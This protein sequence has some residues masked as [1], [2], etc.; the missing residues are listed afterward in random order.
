MYRKV[1]LLNFATDPPFINWASHVTNKHNVNK[2]I[3]MLP[4]VF[5]GDFCLDAITVERGHNLTIG[6]FI[7]PSFHQ[8]LDVFPQ[9]FPIGHLAGCDN[10][11]LIRT[12]C[13]F[14][15]FSTAFFHLFLCCNVTRYSSFHFFQ[16]SNLNL[17]ISFHLS[18]LLIAPLG[19]I[20]GIDRNGLP[21]IK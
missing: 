1:S 3:K 16:K 19:I 15:M 18:R 13:P 11:F 20:S 8:L 14:F 9:F 6:L 12:I 21:I 2:H 5:F 4:F 10:S 7:Y 17:C